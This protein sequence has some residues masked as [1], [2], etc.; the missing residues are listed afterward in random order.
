MKKVFKSIISILLIVSAL[1]SLSSCAPPKIDEVRDTFIDLIE[2]SSAVNRILFGDGLSVYGDLSYDEATKTY[3]CIF[4]NEEYGKLLAYYDSELH[5]YVT[6]R[7][8]DAGEGATVYE[9]A[10]EGIY[11]YP[12]DGVEYTDSNK[13]L[14]ESL[15]PSNY[16]YV[17]VDEVCT[18]INDITAM[19]SLVYSE[20][21]LA[22]IFETTIG[23]GEGDGVLAN[24]NFAAK[25]IEVVDT[26]KGKKY[27]ARADHSYCPPLTTEER[28][29]DF[30][31]MV[32]ARNSRKNYVNVEISSY[33]VYVDVEAGEVKTGWSTVRLSF[34]KQNGEWRLDT[35]TY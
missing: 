2:R 4:Y 11:L 19:A 35:P 23:T 21:Y 18:S 14:P 28:V 7:F 22:E 9:N 32:I 25:Y 34:V 10:E 30:S 17:R 3:Y 29:Y 31:T 8:G 24:E 27:L 20:D 26:E 33:G 16:K 15:L 6:L 13:E 5:E 12:C 1:L